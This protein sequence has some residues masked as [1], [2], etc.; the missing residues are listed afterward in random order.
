MKPFPFFISVCATMAMIT[1]NPIQAADPIRVPIKAVNIGDSGDPVWKIGVM[2]GLGGGPP[3]LYELDTGGGGFWA[4]GGRKGM[5]GWGNFE[6]IPDTN[7]SIE[8]T[9]GNH[10]QATVVKTTVEFYPLERGEALLQTPPV[11]LSR[12]NRFENTKKEKATI[13]WQNAMVRGQPPLFGHFYGDF[14]LSPKSVPQ[15][16]ANFRKGAFHVLGQFTPPEGIRSGYIIHM[17]GLGNQAGSYLQVGFTDQEKE[18]FR[19]QFPMV[20]GPAKFPVTGLSTYPTQMIVDL[21]LSEGG[22]REVFHNI[23]VV[24]DTGAPHSSI[25]QGNLISVGKEFLHKEKGGNRRRSS[26]FHP[27]N[28]LPPGATVRIKGQSANGQPGEILQ[29]HA[30]EHPHIETIAVAAPREK[31]G[32]DGSRFNTGLIIFL[33]Y[34]VLYDMENGIIG[35]RKQR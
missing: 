15:G 14:G 20:A 8:Y 27:G 18:T 4:A 24:V 1:L 7:L 26:E 22:R 33:E 31:D 28:L 13:S 17:N 3:K 35:F 34:D 32:K 30:R 19:T 16:A 21:E 2:I 12:I 25:H 6:E 5:D 23:P 9:S 29:F 10:Y 11:Y